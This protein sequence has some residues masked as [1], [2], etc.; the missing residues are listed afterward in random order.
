MIFLI[1]FI[2]GVGIRKA[3]GRG[4]VAGTLQSDLRECGRGDQTG[5]EQV[6]PGLIKITLLKY[7][8]MMS[9]KTNISFLPLNSKLFILNHHFFL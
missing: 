8:L 6:L 7:N 3:R 5:H 4:R 2:E 9:H 1:Y